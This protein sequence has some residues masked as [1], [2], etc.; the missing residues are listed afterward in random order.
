MEPALWGLI[1]TVVG[2]AASI[3]TTWLTNKNAANLQTAARNAELL[4][5]KRAFQR[6]TIV[7]L[8]D[9]F[10]NAIR[11]ISVAHLE[12]R[13]AHASGA[14]WGKD[15]LPNDLSEQIRLSNRRVML[16]VERVHNDQ[17]RDLVKSVLAEANAVTTATSSE[18]EAVARLDRATMLSVRAIELSG[19]VL[20][21]LY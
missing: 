6:E 10:H 8:Q 13:R 2:A 5:N 21:E 15:L 17:L 4:E 11:N 3:G 12:D 7:E 9:A 1:G 20:R 14:P 18:A 19:T 16:L